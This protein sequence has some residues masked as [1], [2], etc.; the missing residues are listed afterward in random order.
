MPLNA[1]RP[2]MMGLG[3]GRTSSA[4]TKLKM[5]SYLTVA[6]LAMGGFLVSG[7]LFSV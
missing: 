2:S 7:V 5:G 6:A 4:G 1:P 3:F